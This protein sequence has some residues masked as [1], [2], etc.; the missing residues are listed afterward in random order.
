LLRSTE[1]FL[2]FAHDL[3][4]SFKPYEIAPGFSTL[5]RQALQR[6]GAPTSSRHEFGAAC[7]GVRYP[8]GHVD[9][10]KLEGGS[11]RQQR[12]PGF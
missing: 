9:T 11:I 8:A 4:T 1:E 2:I 7:R 6:F 12:S 5:T 10:Y 3:K